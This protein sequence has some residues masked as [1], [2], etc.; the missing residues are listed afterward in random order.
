METGLH[1]APLT[2][3]EQPVLADELTVW[4]WLITANEP[5]EKLLLLS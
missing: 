4:E 5:G 3:E 2:P 1:G